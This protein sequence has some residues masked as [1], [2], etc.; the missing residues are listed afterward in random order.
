MKMRKLF[1]FPANC[2]AQALTLR[3]CGEGKQEKAEAEAK[4]KA[5][6]EEKAKLIF[7]ED[8]KTI[9]GVKGEGIKSITIPDSVTS[10]GS[11][12]FS[13]CSSLTD[14]TIPNGVTSIGDRAFYWC[15]KL[16]SV[17][18]PDSVTSIGSGAFENCISLTS[19]AIG[20]GVTSI[21]DRAFFSCWRLTRV[22]IPSS[23][24]SIGDDAFCCVQSVQVSAGHSVFSVDE[25]GA[26]INKKEKKLL[27]VPPSLSGSYTIPDSVTSIGAGA[28]S[29]CEK[30]TSVTI[31][32]SVTSIGAGAFRDCRS[33]TSVTIPDSVTSIGDDAFTVGQSV[34][35]SAGNPVFS[36]DESGVLINKKEKELLYVPRSLSG[37]YTIP[38]SV[39]S[40]GKN[41]FSGCE[42]LTSV[43]I[44]DSVTSIG[45]GAFGD[46]SRLTSV[47]IPA[48]FTDNDVNRWFYDHDFLFNKVSVPSNCK[49]IRK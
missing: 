25:R 7:S 47:T 36:V 15:E 8:G 2:R 40:I 48:K 49:I 10:I 14:I 1:I 4:A 22:T 42:A 5:E 41:A 46:C 38:D 35:V 34:Q 32:D 27:Y 19:V 33:L 39:T 44:P 29:W 9:T 43:T 12:A 23:V 18:I 24:T 30:L 6:A 26:V 28:F 31:P 11:G 20:N 21:G 37:S 17:T 45:F 3:G 13:W 16:T